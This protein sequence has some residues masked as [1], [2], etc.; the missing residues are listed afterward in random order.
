MA[1]DQITKDLCRKAQQDVT[2]TVNRT[3][4]LLVE[5]ADRMM[6]AIYASAGS[7]ASATAYVMALTEKTTGERP[8]PDAALDVLWE[9]IRPLL[10]TTA[11]GDDAPFQALLAA[12]GK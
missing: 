8:T 11:G 3:A 7:L 4:T 9:M 10:L 6:V 2:A 1:Y 5:P 12:S